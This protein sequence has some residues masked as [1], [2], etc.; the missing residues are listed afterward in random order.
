MQE[1][2]NVHLTKGCVIAGQARIANAL[3]RSPPERR[4][5]P[6][7]TTL[8][9]IQLMHPEAVARSESPKFAGR[10]HQEIRLQTWRPA[11]ARRFQAAAVRPDDLLYG[12][13]AN[14]GGRPLSPQLAAGCARQIRAGASASAA[15]CSWRAPSVK[16]LELRTSGLILEWHVA[17]GAEPSLLA[18]GALLV[19]QILGRE[20]WCLATSH[21]WWPWR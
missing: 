10:R 13:S 17:R 9:R 7:L 18:G 2:E 11:R 14:G 21:V 8:M 16:Q 1:R 15:S 3:R 5:A 4:Y 6:K 20:R 19:A 12:S